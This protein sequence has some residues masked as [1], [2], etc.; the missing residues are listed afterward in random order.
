[1]SLYGMLRTGV[2]GMN[3]QSNKLGTI[4]DNIGN[5]GTA[6]YKRASTEF[7]SL[8]L[9]TTGG[10][11]NSGAV[12]TSVRYAISQQGA[13]NYTTSRTDMM[14]QGNGF[15]MVE[16]ASGQPFLTRAGNFT[17]DGSTGNLV[18]AAGYVL[19]GYD[20][21]NGPAQINLNSTAGMVPINLSAAKFDAVPSTAGSFSANLPTSAA[22][23]PAAQLPSANLATS[24][25][26]AKS[27]ITTYDN[28]GNAV[29]LDIYLS[30]TG[31]TPAAWEMAVYNRANAA[32]GGGFPYAGG[33]LTTTTLNFNANGNLNI[34]TGAGQTR[35]P[36]APFTIPGGQPFS[37]DISNMTNLNAAYTPTD[38]KAN[39]NAASLID[40]VTIDDD[41]VVSALDPSGQK[42]PLFQIPLATVPSADMLEPG[43]GNVF[44]VTA[45]SG[46]IQIG[47]PNQG[48][49]G[50]IVSSATEQ[51][52][53]DM[54][55]EL[56]DMIVA[57]RDY[58][59]NSKVVQ[60][61]S[62]LLDVLMNLKR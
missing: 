28:L 20:I 35:S 8:L 53:V 9:G 44:Q 31:G 24:T 58:T 61:G 36:M 29:V 16:D 50:Y 11:Y 32:A 52:N 27:S 21:T 39:G 43:A 60:T 26:S 12:N 13:P 23:V 19:Q 57:Q 54:A 47:I 37:F 18:N 56:T 3:A 22:V 34:G 51:S 15:F 46:N 14:I 6:G 25:Y 17:V 1:M 30:N 7:S 38:P 49:T 55:T 5:S 41:G 48:G 45:A 59:A 4:A 2:S 10:Q 40:N 42:R 33:P 62:E